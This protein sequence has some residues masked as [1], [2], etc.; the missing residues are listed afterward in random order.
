MACQ[1]C[2][3]KLVI[4][5]PHEISWI[6]DKFPKGSQ[7]HTF[8]AN[9]NY[10]IESEAY[11]DLYVRINFISDYENIRINNTSVESVEYLELRTVVE[12]GKVEINTIR[13]KREV[14]VQAG[15]QPGDY[16][17]LDNMVRLA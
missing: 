6:P 12:G 10:N 9:G 14:Y 2:K 1:I 4:K 5:Q 7:V 16:K 8:K 17:I 11:G 13:G 3:D 15:L